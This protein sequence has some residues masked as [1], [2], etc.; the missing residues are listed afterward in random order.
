MYLHTR[1][2]RKIDITKVKPEDIEIE[3]I[4]HALSQICRFNGHTSC[5]YSVAQH[6]VRVSMSVAPPF[7]LEGLLHDAA[8]A[9]LGDMVRPLKDLI[10]VYRRFEERFT[11][12]IY[13]R[14]GVQSTS[15]SRAAIGVADDNVL[16]DEGQ[17]LGLFEC[18]CGQRHDADAPMWTPHLAK[19][20]FLSKFVEV[21]NVHGADSSRPGNKNDQSH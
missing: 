19:G 3:D 1:T 17:A 18:P 2:G 15:E 8:E 11:K 21:Y 13:E 14:F 20:I 5:F 4:A 10:P 16:M 7:A 6:S 12:I 9:Y